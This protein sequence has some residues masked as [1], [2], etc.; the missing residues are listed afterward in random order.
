MRK[1]KAAGLRWSMV[2]YGIEVWF[3]MPVRIEPVF[4]VLRKRRSAWLNSQQTANL[5]ETAERVAWHGRVRA[6]FPALHV[7]ARRPD[8]VGYLP[9]TA[10]QGAAGAGEPGVTP[11]VTAG[12]GRVSVRDLAELLATPDVARPIL[13]VCEGCQVAFR[14]DEEHDFAACV[15]RKGTGKG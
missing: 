5:R 4:Q 11:L 10:L 13:R 7:V 3:E 14:A 6:D 12:R 8:R 15:A 1:T 2:L 9:R